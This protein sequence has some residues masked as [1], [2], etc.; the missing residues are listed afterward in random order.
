M[1]R[2]RAGAC[3]LVTLFLAVGWLWG[4][5][6]GAGKSKGRLPL[7]WSKLGLSDEQRTKV[8]SVRADY[9]A[10]I[11]AL[12]QQIADLEKRERMELERVLTPEQK[13]ALRK[14]VA[15]KTVGGG[16]EPSAKE[17]KKSGGKA[18]KEP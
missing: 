4:Q 5:D 17:E 15:S 9:Q 7:Y 14:I 2:L 3:L 1:S 16:D 6:P 8:A 10:K 13:A 11:D 18:K 12:K